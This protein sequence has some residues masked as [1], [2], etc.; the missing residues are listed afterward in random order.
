MSNVKRWFVS[1]HPG[2][3]EWLATQQVIVDEVVPHLNVADVAKGDYVY[4]TLPINLVAEICA[5]GAFYLHLSLQIPAQW[6]GQELTLEQLKA[7]QAH[8][9]AFTASAL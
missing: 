7:C 3:L 5:K 6:R 1:R 2:A 4:G 9:Q 8:F